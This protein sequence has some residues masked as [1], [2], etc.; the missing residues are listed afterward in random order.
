MLVW[1]SGELQQWICADGVRYSAGMMINR[2][3]YMKSAYLDVCVQLLHRDH[4]LIMEREFQEVIEAG[5]G[6]VIQLD[7]AL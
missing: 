7:E 5:G 3:G 1:F 2:H 4:K 6:H